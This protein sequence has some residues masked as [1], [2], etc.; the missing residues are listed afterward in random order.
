MDYQLQVITS[1]VSD[2]GKA[3]GFCSGQAGSALDVDYHPASDSRVAQPTPPGPACPAQI[4]AGPTDAP[5][6]PARATDPAVT[7]I[8]AAR[9]ELTGRGITASDI[10]HKPP[11]GNWTGGIEPGTDPQPRDHASFAGFADPDGN[12]WVIQE[13]GHRPTGGV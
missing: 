4:G 6:G 8:Q 2:A 12:T 3:A 9:R 13:I 5:P 1:S 10:R 7:G 11:T